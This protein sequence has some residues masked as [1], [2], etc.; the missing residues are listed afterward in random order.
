[1]MLD[2]KNSR[3]KILKEFKNFSFNKS[4]LENKKNLERSFKKFK[5]QIVIHL[6]AQ[7]GCKI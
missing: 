5:P 4:K 1:M 2:L 3:Y 7:A 6:A